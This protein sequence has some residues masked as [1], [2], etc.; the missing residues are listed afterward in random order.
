MGSDSE[1]IQL[2]RG[3]GTVS[4]Q[5]AHVTSWAKPQTTSRRKNLC[6][7]NLGPGQG[8]ETQAAACPSWSVGPRGGGALEEV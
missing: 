4:S 8:W 6:G 3:R 1:E 2:L 5:T 7:S